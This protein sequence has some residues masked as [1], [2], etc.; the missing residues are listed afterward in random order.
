MEGA[1]RHTLVIA[2]AALAIGACP[3]NSEV[4][5]YPPRKA[6]VN[7]GPEARSREQARRCHRSPG[8]RALV[9]HLPAFAARALAVAAAEWWSRRSVRQ[10]AEPPLRW[11][12]VRGVST[13]V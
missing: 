3:A 11:K 13:T 5:H 12:A 7:F 2:S 6:S 4:A 8:K 1:R 10:Q 9:S